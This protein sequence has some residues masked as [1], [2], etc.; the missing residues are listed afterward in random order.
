MRN[1]CLLLACVLIP[2]IC[3]AQEK[4]DTATVEKK[5]E[6]NVML[7]ASDA[8][9]PRY[10][11][12]GL[13]SEDVNVY[14][15]GLPTVYSSYIH[16]LQAHWRSDGSLSEVG[17]MTPQESA[18]AT[19]NIA[20]SVNSFSDLGGDEFKGIINYKGNHYGMHQF[21]LNLSGPLRGGVVLCSEHVPGLRPWNL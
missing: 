12:I 5:A 9:A 16:P 6:R 11:Q 3:H 15:N 14:E 19:G 1:R 8:N 10:I 21:D 4:T 13:P 18:I 17:L 2:S 7:N 20:Y